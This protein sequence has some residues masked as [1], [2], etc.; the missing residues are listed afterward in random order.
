M[1]RKSVSSQS[2]ANLNIRIDQRLKG[3]IEKR[4]AEAGLTVTDFVTDLMRNLV[5]GS[6]NPFLYSPGPRKLVEQ[7][8]IFDEDRHLMEELQIAVDEG[9]VSNIDDRTI[10]TTVPRALWIGKK[11]EPERSRS[12]MNMTRNFGSILQSNIIMKRLVIDDFPKWDDE[13]Y[14]GF[15]SVDAEFRDDVIARA[16]RGTSEAADF[17]PVGK[18]FQVEHITAQDVLG[19][20]GDLSDREWLNDVMIYGRRAVSFTTHTSYGFPFRSVFSRLKA[21]L[22][23]WTRRFDEIWEMAVELREKRQR[24][25]VV[26]EDA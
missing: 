12:W 7:N 25:P 10:R 19:R 26:E 13:K 24:K 6:H 5:E 9:T 4:A 15:R 20:P 1:P 23:Y 22:D 17:D 21:D 3:K 11:L 8:Q 14:R 16:E 18:R 2:P